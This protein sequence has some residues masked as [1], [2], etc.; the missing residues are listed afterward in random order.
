[1]HNKTGADY[2]TAFARSSRLCSDALTAELVVQIHATGAAADTPRAWRGRCKRNGSLFT[3]L[4]QSVRQFLISRLDNQNGTRL[5]VGDFAIL[6]FQV[7][8][9]RVIG[10]GDGRERLAFLDPVANKP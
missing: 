4:R 5:Q 10:V 7:G 3:A 9:C 6:T 2:S 1:M 8:N